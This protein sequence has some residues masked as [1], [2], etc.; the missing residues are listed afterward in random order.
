MD[1]TREEFRLE[2]I[3]K[4]LADCPDQTTGKVIAV[5]PAYNAGPFIGTPI[6][7]T[8]ACRGAITSITWT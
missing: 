8:T 1:A 4:N 2:G 5:L 7:L 6:L 3:L